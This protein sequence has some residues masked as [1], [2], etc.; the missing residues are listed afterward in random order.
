[1]LRGYRA[2]LLTILGALNKPSL[3]VSKS[4]RKDLRSFQKSAASFVIRSVLVSLLFIIQSPNIGFDNF[5]FIIASPVAAKEQRSNEI[6]AKTSHLSHVTITQT[7]KPQA[8][9]AR[10]LGARARIT[11]RGLKSPEQ[12]MLTGSDANPPASGTSNVP[13]SAA[14]VHVSEPTGTH[15]GESVRAKGTAGN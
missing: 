14:V 1:M 13:A 11:E 6:T 4:L 7:T 12:S 15:G 9:R 10:N 5:A 8:A 2:G 3:G